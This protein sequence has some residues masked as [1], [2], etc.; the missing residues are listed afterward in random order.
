MWCVVLSSLCREGLRWSVRRGVRGVLRAGW[1]KSLSSR[2][3]RRVLEDLECLGNRRLLGGAG[4]EGYCCGGDRGE[5]VRMSFWGKNEEAKQKFV[6]SFRPLLNTL[7]PGGIPTAAGG[8]VYFSSPG[9]GFSSL[10]GFKPP[11]VGSSIFPRALWPGVLRFSRVRIGGFS[12]P[13]LRR[14]HDS[15]KAEVGVSLVKR[16]AF[17]IFFGVFLYVPKLPEWGGLGA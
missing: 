3:R 16:S 17:F 2:L 7:L 4:G 12:S 11:C 1:R 9:K 10:F 6:P 13:P 8:G 15:W 14:L 5:G